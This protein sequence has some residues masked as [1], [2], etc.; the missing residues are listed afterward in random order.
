MKSCILYGCLCALALTF[1]FPVLSQ[2]KVVRGDGHIVTDTRQVGDF[3]KLECSGSYHIVL[4]QGGSPSLR[5]DAD[6]NLMP[7]IV[8]ETQGGSL[9]LK[10]K[11]HVTIKP[12]RPVMIYLSVNALKEISVSGACNLKTTNKLETN[13]LKVTVS[14]SADM[15]MQMNC[16]TL[17]V[18]VSGSGK[19]SLSGSSQSGSYQISGSANVDASALV[20]DDTHVQV[21]GMGKLHVD[22][23]KKLTVSISGMGN[24]T[25]KGS[26]EI[27][28]SVS[29]MGKLAKE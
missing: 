26:P 14:G 9:K 28:Q 24:V 12:S 16:Q 7:Y 4:T 3:N 8:T 20:T 18:S 27:S 5:V 13:G 11:D 21:S 19:F 6:E 29:G 15:M 2:P 22:A 10:T 25:Y 23:E 17:A 1:S